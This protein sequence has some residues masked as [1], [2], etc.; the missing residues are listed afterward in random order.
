MVLQHV[1]QGAVFVIVGPAVADPHR[2]ADRDLHVVDGQVV[3]QRLEDRV[4]EPQR[5]QVLDRLLA[6]IVVDAEDLVLAEGVGHGVV[7]FEEGLQVAPNRLFQHDAA[8]L[9]GKAR[10]LH[11]CDDAGIE[12]RGYGQEGGDLAVADLVLQ[13]LET[14]GRGG[15]HRQIVQAG[16]HSRPAGFV[17]DLVG[18]GACLN[19]LVHLGDI[20]VG[21]LFGARGADDLQ[22]VGQQA[23][24]FEEIERR[25]KHAHRQIAAAAK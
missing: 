25:Q 15:V 16:L 10:R 2:F 23:V 14:F 17:P 11:R 18:L 9:F 1:A 22:T 7:D 3:P 8:V 13:R 5:D 12:R 4:A 20:V 24:V 19:R 6:Q 21:A